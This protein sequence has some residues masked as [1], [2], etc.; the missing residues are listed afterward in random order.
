MELWV[1][2]TVKEPE[3]RAGRVFRGGRFRTMDPA[4]PEAQA[5]GVWEGRL[6]Y[7]GEDPAAAEESVRSRARAAGET[8]PRAVETV[9][10]GGRAAV[11]GLIDSHSHLIVEGVRL[12]QLDV[13]GKS[14]PEAAELVR[15]K[16]ASLP[17][18]SWLHGR[19]WDHNLWP[20]RGWPSRKDLDEAAGDAA[21]VLDRVDKHSVW[22]NS[23]ALELAGVRPDA[24]D[25]P[26]GEIIREADGSLRGVLVGRAMRLVYDSMP[27]HDGLD[28]LEAYLAAERE[29][30]S[31]GLTTVIDCGTRAGDFRVLDKAYQAG[32]ATVRFHSFLQPE[33]WAEEILSG[34]PRRGLYGGKFSLDG[35]KLFSDGSLGSQSAWLAEDYADRP[36]HRGT[37]YY[38]DGELEAVLAKIRDRGLQ[39]AIHV[40]GDA[41]AAQAVRAMS[42]VL[43][44]GSAARRWRLEHLQVAPP[45]LA[46]EAAALGLIPSIQSVGL[47]TDLHMALS[48]LGLRRLRDAYTWRRL[49]ELS[50]LLINGS[51]APIETPDPFQGIYAAC[52]RRD[53]DWRPE[54]GFRPEEGLTVIEALSSYTAWPAWAAFAEHDVGVLAEGRYADITVL[55]RDLRSVPVRELRGARALMT[56]IGGRPAWAADDF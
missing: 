15:A 22:V 7:V 21:V 41:A 51:D 48:R 24:A 23:K 47:M 13:S 27:L 25:P 9:D 31:L 17:P 38:S 30:L 50:G 40:I 37:H 2:G 16:A 45:A 14:L 35:V 34:G 52:A 46:R 11:P 28:P 26:G 56:V 3:E 4:N 20:G 18:G 53:L 8:G 44:A 6:V 29:M 39:A 1:P 49:L 43:G 12:S 54:E 36:G 32:A 42:K 19:G 55:D 5:L 10:L 33:P